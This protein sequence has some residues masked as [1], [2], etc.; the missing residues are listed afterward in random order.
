MN[1]WHVDYSL[2]AFI[3]NMFHWIRSCPFKPKDVLYEICTIQACDI[4]QN[5]KDQNT[6]VEPTMYRWPINNSFQKYY[7]LKYFLEN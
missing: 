2:Q 4:N 1:Q 6:L 7:K 3:E 5:I